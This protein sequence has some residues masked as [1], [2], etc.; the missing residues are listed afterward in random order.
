MNMGN[1]IVALKRW[2]TANKKKLQNDDEPHQLWRFFRVP[3]MVLNL[4]YWHWRR[5]RCSATRDPYAARKFWPRELSFRVILVL[6]AEIFTDAISPTRYCL[7]LVEVTFESGKR[8]RS[9]VFMPAKRVYMTNPF[10]DVGHWR[11]TQIQIKVTSLRSALT[12]FATS[13]GSM[14]QVSS[15]SV[16]LWQII[17]HFE[18]KNNDCRRTTA[19]YR[20]GAE[21]AQ[22]YCSC[23]LRKIFKWSLSYCYRLDWQGDCPFKWIVI[24]NFSITNCETYEIINE[25]NSEYLHLDS[26]RWKSYTTDWATYRICSVSMLD[27]RLY[28]S[29]FRWIS[30]LLNTRLI[31]SFSFYIAKPRVVTFWSLE[32][33]KIFD[34]MLLAA[35][36]AAFRLIESLRNI[37]IYKYSIRK[38]RQFYN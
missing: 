8:K 12:I 14:S 6:L 22:P 24:F 20:F 19:M 18:N 21:P 9:G 17:M 32:L 38:D 30:W 3:K 13:G 10:P 31:G 36:L 35:C 29:H 5:Q 26:G 7:I 23:E 25:I 34:N 37:S 4:G 11:L 15:I 28:F 1:F 27:K 33:S 16:R 2:P